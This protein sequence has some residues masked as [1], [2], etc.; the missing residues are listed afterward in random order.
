MEVGDTLKTNAIQL[1]E[2]KLHIIKIRKCRVKNN[3]YIHKYKFQRIWNLMYETNANI[4]YYRT[5][6]FIFIFGIY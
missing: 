3:N 2:V 5:N 6:M 4:S 1:K